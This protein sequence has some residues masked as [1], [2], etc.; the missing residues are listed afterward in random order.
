MRIGCDNCF[1]CGPNR[2]SRCWRLEGRE[3]GLVVCWLNEKGYWQISHPDL[4]VLRGH[5]EDFCNAVHA[6]NYADRD[7]FQRPTQDTPW[8]NSKP[9]KGR[10]GSHRRFLGCVL[11][12]RQAASGSWFAT[13]D[14]DGIVGGFHP[15]EE[16]AQGEAE[17]AAWSKKK[18]RA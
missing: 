5:F 16:L 14:N 17:F 12:V 13:I 1:L 6:Y 3:D 15:T 10:P 11:A 7:D 4:G 8:I 9:K 18:A 2:T